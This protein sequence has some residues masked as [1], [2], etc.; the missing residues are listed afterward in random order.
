MRF[1]SH[2]KFLMSNKSLDFCKFLKYKIK[3]INDTEGKHMYIYIYIYIS[4]VK[5]NALIMR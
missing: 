1:I 3:R 5:V 2:M 4:A